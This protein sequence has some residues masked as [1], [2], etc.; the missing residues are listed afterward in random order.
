[1]RKLIATILIALA[2]AVFLFSRGDYRVGVVEPQATRVPENVA[3]QYIVGQSQSNPS[4]ITQL[5]VPISDEQEITIRWYKPPHRN[6]L[7]PNGSWLE[8]YEYYKLFAESGSG[9]AAYQLASMMS[10]C[11]SAFLNRADLD[12]AIVQM[13]R[14]FTYFDPKLKSNVRI[15]EP[16]KVNEYIESYIDHFESCKDFTAGQ[17]DE[18]EEWM[19]LAANNGY[20][21]AMLEYG[22]KLDDPIASVELYRNAW[23][24]GDG[25]ALFSLAK[26]LEQMYDEGIDPS[27]KIPAFAAMHAYVMLLRSAHG[28]N[29]DRVVGRWTLRNQAKLDEMAKVMFPDELEAAA[30]LSSRLLKIALKV[31]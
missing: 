17:R 25:H 19:E 29:P 14:T 26:G 10:S 7:S 4:A 15:G 23:R 13:Q 9:I 3:N 12:E 6:F 28:T 18:H 27:A 16:E 22:R 31:A 24:Q 21:T 30:D 11:N 5:D 8:N 20:T 2:L 1:M